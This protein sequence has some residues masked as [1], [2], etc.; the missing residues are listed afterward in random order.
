MESRRRGAQ[1]GE[2]DRILED[3][4]L[5]PNARFLTGRA[6]RFLS[7]SSEEEANTEDSFR[8]AG[9]QSADIFDFIVDIFKYV[10]DT[11]I[12]EAMDTS[13]AQRHLT[14][15][16]ATATCKAR[17]TELVAKAIT[18]KAEEIG[19]KVNCSKTQLLVIS[20][21]NGY[22][23]RS[24]IDI[25]GVRIESREE[26][27]LLGFFF[28]SEPNVNCHVAEIQRRFR[29]RF[30]ALIHLRR[31][32]FKG[33][34]LFS[35]YTVFV[36]PV[37]EFCAVVYHS[38]LTSQQSIALERLQKQVIKLAYGWELSY[39]EACSRYG[40]E[41]LEDRRKLMLDRF[42]AKTL[43]NPRFAEDWYPLRQDGPNVRNRRIYMETCA[44]TNRYY[45]SPLA[46]M[47]R[48][49]NDMLTA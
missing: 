15:A 2:G 17:Y 23:N 43:R 13:Q 40:I 36:R 30:W 44:R 48:R 1:S 38:L 4:C 29:A 45:N 7:S 14:T 5:G 12:V 49:A 33:K 47:R 18:S 37:I 25:N 22:C 24:F 26:M 21:P 9:D 32:G 41:S 3:S 10:D 31:S 11:T 46:L 28:G 20:P 34:E 35:L 16:T 19:M 39:Q 42:V 8:T 27:K 6:G